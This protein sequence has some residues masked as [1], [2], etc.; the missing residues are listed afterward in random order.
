LSVFARAIRKDWS[1]PF[2]LYARF[3]VRPESRTSIRHLASSDSTVSR[4]QEEAIAIHRTG[5]TGARGDHGLGRGHLAERALGLE[6]TR[7]KR[8]PGSELLRSIP[9][10]VPVRSYLVTENLRSIGE[11]SIPPF[12]LKWMLLAEGVGDEEPEWS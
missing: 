2:G 7:I 5:G 6:P 8:E 4:Y 12:D 3:W 11:K 10:C 9:N 1:N